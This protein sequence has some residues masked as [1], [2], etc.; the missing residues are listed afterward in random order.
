MYLNPYFWLKQNEILL[1]L[2]CVSN[3][4]I[5]RLTVETQNRILGTLLDM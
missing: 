4:R 5:Y 3:K 1:T 2:Q